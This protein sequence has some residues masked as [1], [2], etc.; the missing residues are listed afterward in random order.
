[1]F[2]DKIVVKNKKTRKKGD[3]TG[4]R[5]NVMPVRCPVKNETE[6]NLLKRYNKRSEYNQKIYLYY[7]CNI[8]IRNVFIG[9][10]CKFK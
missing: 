3:P 1:L 5:L 10:S 7:C 9:N 8:N 2:S 6:V 4:I